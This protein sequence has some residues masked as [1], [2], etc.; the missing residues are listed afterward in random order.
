MSR[1]LYLYLTA[2][3]PQRSAVCRWRLLDGDAAPH[4][5]ESAPADWPPA[6]R[7]V[8]ILSVDQ[9]RYALPTLP[10]GLRWDDADALAMALEEQ[11][12]APLEQQVVVPLR[13]A[14]AGTACAVVQRAR[15]GALVQHFAALGRPLARIECEADKL[16]PSGEGWRILRGAGGDWLHDGT[17]AYALDA[18]DGTAL[19]VVLQL[20][21]EQA[22]P[23]APAWLALAGADAD[24]AARY[25]RL[26]GIE[27][28]AAPPYA[29][30]SHCTRPGVN[31]LRG[32]LAPRSRWF[33]LQRARLAAALLLLALIGQAGMDGA[34][35]LRA[36][37]EARQ[38]RAQQRALL[39]A[40][41]IADGGIRPDLA[42]RAAW[43]AARSRVGEPDS[44]E[45]L[46]MLATVA[47]ALPVGAWHSIAFDQGKLTVQWDGSPDDA[48][49]AERKLAQAGYQ[50]A[51]KRN[52]DQVATALRFNGEP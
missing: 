3:W 2:D 29:W 19:P 35:W 13:A 48:A 24:E 44:G 23:R 26:S 45:L 6:R 46:P 11:L 40:G 1:T 41:E 22:G 12:A 5:A 34:G 52:G 17:L 39:R 50:T 10:P 25:T 43:A 31:L 49:R 37:W 27:T 30:Q 8:A 18:A 47:G 14:G 33:D 28:R 21:L 16:P 7:H 42:L 36:S 9:V 51:T 4:D 20:A 15:L 32:E 38:L